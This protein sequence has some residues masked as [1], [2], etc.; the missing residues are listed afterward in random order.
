VLLPRAAQTIARAGALGCAIVVLT[1]AAC[2][3]PAERIR[4]RAA[5]LGYTP[6]RL[7]GAGFTH[8]AFF[9]GDPRGSSTLHV[10]IEHDGTPWRDTTQ[11]A[12]DPTP[13]APVALELMARDTGPRLYLGRPCYFE[14]EDAPRCT[15]MMWTHRRYSPEVVDSMVAALRRFLASQPYERVVLIGYS[16][17]GTLAW[18]IAGKLTETVEVVTIIANLDTDAWTTLHGFSP[19]A[20]SL[21]PALQPDL[22]PSIRQLHYAGCRDENVPPSVLKSFAR[23]HPQARITMIPDFDHRC[24]WIDRWPELLEAGA[25]STNT[26]NEA[27]TCD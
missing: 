26:D 1:L 5:E 4:S 23:H 27:S 8:A 15:P 24:C 6:I 3:T 19:L 13:R 16:G 25:R 14:P 10:Y 7:A 9:A 2:A 20:G 18:L 22:P 21:N 11:V 12:N 17:G